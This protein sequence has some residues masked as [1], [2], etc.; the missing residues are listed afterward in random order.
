MGPRIRSFLRTKGVFQSDRAPD[1]TETVNGIA[2]SYRL[3]HYR[4]MPADY[5]LTA[6]DAQWEQQPGN[7]ISYG[8]DAKEEQDV[9]FL[10]WEKDGVSYSIM[11]PGARVSANTLF[12]VAQELLEK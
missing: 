4:L 7:H 10:C 5:K 12:S 2:L 3:D 1:R 9:A 11:D 8:S 6:E